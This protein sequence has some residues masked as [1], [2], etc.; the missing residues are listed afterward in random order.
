M[1]IKYISTN[2]NSYNYL[3]V[4]QPYASV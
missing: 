1:S 4:E 2:E 3:Y